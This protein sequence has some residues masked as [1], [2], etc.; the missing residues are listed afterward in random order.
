MLAH[1]KELIEY[2]NGS[3]WESSKSERSLPQKQL[4]QL[5]QQQ[6]RPGKTNQIR[7]CFLAKEVIV[8][9]ANIW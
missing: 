5:T 6:G 2:Q 8:I 3:T 9:D 1:C 4:Q 7:D